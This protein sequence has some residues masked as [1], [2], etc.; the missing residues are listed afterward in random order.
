MIN[1]MLHVHSYVRVWVYPKSVLT[2]H[3]QTSPV[4]ELFQLCKAQLSYKVLV[5]SHFVI[6]EADIL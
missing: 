5:L 4:L 3:T 6:L 2:I 1:A